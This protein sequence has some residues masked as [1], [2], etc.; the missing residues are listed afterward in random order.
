M[1]APLLQTPISVLLVVLF[2]SNGNRHVK[3]TKDG[4]LPPD[5]SLPPNAE[6]QTAPSGVWIRSDQG[7]DCNR[8]CYESYQNDW[9]RPLECDPTGMSA[10]QTCSQI[11]VQE[12]SF[13]GNKCDECYHSD[14]IA[15]P[16]SRIR[17]IETTVG[18]IHT[19]TKTRECWVFG[20]EGRAKCDVPLYW[21]RTNRPVVGHPPL[22]YDDPNQDWHN[23][24]RDVSETFAICKCKIVEGSGGAAGPPGPRGLPGAAGA[25]GAGPQGPPGAA[26]V[27][28]VAGPPGPQ[29]P[30]GP[31]AGGS[32]G[33]PGA[34]GPPGESEHLD[35]HFAGT[36]EIQAPAPAP[37]SGPAPEPASALE[38]PSAQ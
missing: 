27:D 20:V 17:T 1:A 29:G 16:I 33:P 9:R 38:A 3:R 6:N 36:F 31:T 13:M 23:W 19:L 35:G 11:D 8:T 5:P 37:A 2:S 28:G 12:G 22:D 30:P 34:P 4:P 14:T 7:W 18:G 24:G 15:A 10:I 26:G 21:P 32:A 25:D